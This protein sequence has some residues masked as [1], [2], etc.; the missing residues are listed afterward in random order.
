MKSG[1]KNEH[2]RKDE[3]CIFSKAQN[4]GPPARLQK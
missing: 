2:A 3:L 1:S 4:A